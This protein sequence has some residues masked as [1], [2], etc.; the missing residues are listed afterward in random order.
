MPPETLPCGQIDAPAKGQGTRWPAL[1]L[2]FRPFYLAASAF[3]ALAVPLW[4]G[5]YFGYLAVDGYLQGA[6]WHAHEMIFGF[7][8]AVVTG[9]LFTAVRQWTGMA[10]PTGGLLGVFVL[11][12]AVGRVLAVT[13]PAVPAAVVDGLFLPAVAAAIV[14][15]ILR[16][17]NYRNLFVVAVIGV[18]AVANILFH[19]N[20]WG[21]VGAALDRYAVVLSFDVLTVLMAV[22]GGRVI[23]LFIGNAVG[24]SRPRRVPLVEV[25]ALGSLV[26][27]LALDAVAPW[28]PVGSAWL[29]VIAAIAAA[30]HAVRLWLWDPL[31]ARRQP[32]LWMLPVAYAWIPIALAL[33]AAAAASDAV[34]V[35]L[36]E[37]ALGIGAMSGLMLAMM[38][39]SAL[40]HTGRALRAGWIETTAFLLVQLSA[41]LRMGSTFI[42]PE[43][44]EAWLSLSALCWSAAFLV[45]F[46]G[47]WPILT[48]PR[49]D[50]RAG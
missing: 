11:L 36:S 20:A 21:R 43:L 46:V 3:A 22:V 24:G 41:L 35:V 30:F 12:W 26:L 16:S 1:A 8:A 38:S 42:W 4:I 9:F 39:R 29:A 40:G 2:G 45:F 50:G 37:H 33:R 19:L 18:L 5:Q 47:Y 44:V 32:L 31:A 23:P 34:P 14:V 17:R 49:V 28:A 27:I 6:A 13:G 10:T 7:A 15:P 25:G 48:R